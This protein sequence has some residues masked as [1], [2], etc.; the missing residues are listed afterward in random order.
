MPLTPTEWKLIDRFKEPSSYAGLTAA[1]GGFGIT[2]PAG[3]LQTISYLGA[4]IC[5]ALSIFLKEN[6]A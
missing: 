6:S 1:L 5:L 3:Y 2:L 4:G